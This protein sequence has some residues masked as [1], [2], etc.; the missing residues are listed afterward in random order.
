MK[1]FMDRAKEVFEKYADRTAFIDGDDK[2]SFREI[3]EESA[4]IYAY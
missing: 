3:D 4:R 2:I 1:R